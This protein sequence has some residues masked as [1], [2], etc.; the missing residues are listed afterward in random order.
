M[1]RSILI[2]GLWVT[3]LSA[4]ASASLAQPY[5]N[6]PIQLIIPNV[7]GSIL[8]ITSRLFAEDLGKIL[9]TQII[10]VNKP[11]A[12]KGRPEQ[13]GGF[14]RRRITGSFKP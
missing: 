10:P 3:V 12:T 14:F 13:I 1:K 4:G 6:R 5:P 2:V 9:G 7:A 11:G 8:D